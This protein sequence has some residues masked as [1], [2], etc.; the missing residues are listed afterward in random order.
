MID[1]NLEKIPREKICT[2]PTPIQYMSRLSEHL[3]GINVYVKR[4]D[5]TGIALGGN[6]NRKVEYLLG[7]AL[8]KNCDTIITEGTITSNHCL[9]AA[10]G[11]S[12]LGLDCHVVLSDASI[13]EK[14]PM[15]L[16]F[17]MLLDV[18]IYR[19]KNNSERK[20][21][22]NQ[23]SAKLRDEG[24][25]PYIIPSGGSDRIGIFGYVNFFKEIAQQSND[26]GI[27]FDYFIHGTGSAGTQAGSIVGKKIFYPSIEVIGINAG[28]VREKIISNIKR[29]ISEFESDNDITL[30]IND[31][32][33]IVLDD[34]IGEGY[35]ILSNKIIDTVKLIAKFEGIF[36]DP[37]YNSKAM[38][39][40]LGLA[41]RK[42][43]PKNSNI[44]FL[45]SGGNQ[46][47]YHFIDN[48]LEKL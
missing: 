32:D 14:I 29:I 40:L 45:H 24:K 20:P 43:F 8:S 42:Y 34:F 39:G 15:N 21:M 13:G 4:D 22:M 10:A 7:D 11:A 19:V 26:L 3:K 46:A 25:N 23:I 36:L 31:S 12:K 48:L 28:Y 1:F 18:K 16:L 2:L 30:S 6:K 17:K 27:T 47:F 35:E 44:L 38:I 37:V 5:L 9:Q 41:Q 33:I